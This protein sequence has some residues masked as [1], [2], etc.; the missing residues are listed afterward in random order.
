VYNTIVLISP[1]PSC[2]LEMGAALL[3]EHQTFNRDTGRPRS[4]AFEEALFRWCSFSQL[5]IDGG[6]IGGTL[7]GCNLREVD[8]YWGSFN[9]ALVAHT[10][11]KNCTFRGSSFRGC[12][13]VQCQFDGCRFLLDNLGAP[14]SFDDCVAVECTFDGCEV[15]LESPSGK[16]VFVSTRWYGCRQNESLGLKGLF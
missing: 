3:I 10:S 1:E 8:W 7:L 6:M 14:C 4:P 5:E 2:Y 11:F 16:P 9:T 13:F 15:I 12:E